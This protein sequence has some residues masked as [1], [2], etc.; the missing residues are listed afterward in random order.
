MTIIILQWNARSIIANGQE[1][2]KFINDLPTLPDIICVQETWLKPQLNFVRPG[3]K[4]IV[5]DRIVTSAGGCATFVKN[6]VAYREIIID[7]QIEC[8]I[9]EVWMDI[10][11]VKIVNFYNPCNQLTVD[12]L[13]S[14][15]GDGKIGWCGDFNVHNVLWESFTTDRNGAILEEYGMFGMFK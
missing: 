10:G 15:G 9:I 8:V 2:K 5:E 1:F 7:T 13:N 12:S 3:Y 6:G 11:K 4:T 14:I